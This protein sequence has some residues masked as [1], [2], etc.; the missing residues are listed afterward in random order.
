MPKIEQTLGDVMVRSHTFKFISPSLTE[1]LKV[2]NPCTTCHTDK[3]TAWAT[4][5]LKTWLE[6]SPWRVGP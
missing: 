6:F 1:Q 3:P 2:P 5:A 4:A